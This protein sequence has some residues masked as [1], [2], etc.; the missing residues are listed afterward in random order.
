MAIDQDLN[1][2]KNLEQELKRVVGTLRKGY[3][4]QKILLFGSLVQ[5]RTHAW[6]DIDL[7][8][9]KATQKRF[10]ERLKEVALLTQ[11]RVGIDFFVY[12]PEEFQEMISERG[13]FQRR[14][15]FEK[16]KVL[17]DES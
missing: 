15:M 9:V 8:I 13:T 7:V 11:P 17:Y 5:G 6:S 14:E 4:P 16:G 1:R 12:T 2:K 3:K 10:V